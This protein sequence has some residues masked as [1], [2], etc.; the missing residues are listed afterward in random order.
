MAMEEEWASEKVER[1]R[2]V[3]RVSSARLCTPSFIADG[4]DG[5]L[6]RERAP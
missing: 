2:A 6:R 3:E 5:K 4:L 1:E